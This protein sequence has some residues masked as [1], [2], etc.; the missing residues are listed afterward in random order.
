M[1]K[2]IDV[3]I[4]EIVQNV[5]KKIEL[6]IYTYIYIFNYFSIKMSR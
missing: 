4:K 6:Y 3:R 1:N 2:K 5:K